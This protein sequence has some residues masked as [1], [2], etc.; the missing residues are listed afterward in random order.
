MG[1]AV[2]PLS[3]WGL[4]LESHHHRPVDID[5]Y[6]PGAELD[7]AEAALRAAV[8]TG[9]GDF[10]QFTVAPGQR[11]V[12]GRQ[13]LRVPVTVYLGAAEF[14]RFH[15]DLVTGIEMTGLPDEVEALVSIELPG[16]RTARYLAYPIADHIAD[17]VCAML[18]L[19]PRAAGPAQASTRYRD[20]A[21]LALIAHTQRVAAEPLERALASEAQRRNLN[22]PAILPTPDA[23]GW[24]AGYARVARDVPGLL[25]RDLDSAVATVRRLTDPILAG[26]TTGSWEPNRLSWAPERDVVG[27]GGPRARRPTVRSQGE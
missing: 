20:L 13:T 22:L 27:R 26:T 7:T 24:R 18:E 17:K 5:L 1:D 23:P 16:I 2:A 3:V 19:H 4:G 12:E 21:D 25:E 14:A 11:V 6:R 15:V 9:I 10:F 8:A